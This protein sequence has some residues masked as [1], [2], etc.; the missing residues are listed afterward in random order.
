MH[1]SKAGYVTACQQVLALAVVVAVL[2]P[3]AGV[4]SLDVVTREPT[5]GVVRTPATGSG[6]GSVTGSGAGSV[7]ASTTSAVVPT[8]PVDA[9]VREIALTPAAGSSVTPDGRALLRRTARGRTKLV[10]QPAAVDGFG[11]VGVTWSAADPIAEGAITLSLRTRTGDAWTAWQ[12][13][14]Y[15]PDHGPDPGSA[16][17]RK[18]RPGS[19]PVVLG[20]VDDVQVRTVTS[21]GAPADMKLAVIG[22]GTPAATKVEAPAIDTN[23]LPGPTAAAARSAVPTGAAPTTTT[24]TTTAAPPTAGRGV[25]SL[26]GGSTPEGADLEGAGDIALQDGPYTPKPVI[27][28]RAQ[29][30]ADESMRDASSLHYGEVHAGFIHHT[31]NANDYSAAEVPGIIRSI[32]A[33]HVRSRG[34]SDIGYNYLID[35]FGRIWEGRYGGVTLDPVGAHTLNYND[36]SFGASAIGNYQITQPSEAL[37]QAYARLF[38]WKLAM[39]GVPAASTR[40]YVTSRYFEAIN[41]HRDA[42]ATLCPG[43]YL[44]AQ[45]PRIRALAASYQARW[46]G[47]QR[48]TDLDGGGWPDFVIHLGSTGATDLLQTRGLIRLSAPVT[49]SASGWAGMDT[50]VASPDLTG[51]GRVD[52]VSRDAATGVA[53]VH[54]GDGAGHVG[55]GGHPTGLLAG[56][57]EITAVG[58][59]DHDGH[60]DLFARDPVSGRAYLFSGNGAGSFTRHLLAMSWPYDATVGVGD[61]NGD[62]L[63]DLAARDATGQLWLIPGAGRFDRV[64]TRLLLGSGWNQFD[65]ITG[66]GDWTG[67]GRPDIVARNANGTYVYPNVRN[68][69]LGHWL[70][71]IGTTTGTTALSSGGSSIGGAAPDLVVRRGDALLTYAHAG[72]YHTLPPKALSIDMTGVTQILNVGDWDR[73][74]DD[75]LVLRTRSGVLELLLNN[76]HGVFAA[77]RVLATGF[78]DVQLLT[79]VGDYNGDGYPDLMGQIGGTM[80]VWTGRG[81]AGLNNAYVAHT[82]IS[83]TDQIGVGLWDLDGAPDTMAEVN[84][85]AVLY[86]GNGPGGLTTPRATG[87]S[88]SPYDWV[89]GDG[90]INGDGHP[91]LVVRQR[92]TGYLWVLPG[93]TA[94]GFSPRIFLGEG[95]G[96]FD[97]AG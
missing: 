16:E 71:S 79:A 55:A 29:W 30:G 12:S 56:F 95:Y 43:K 77:P 72:T 89:L 34:W 38:A 53:T 64:G 26:A 14:P 93:T 21:A 73:D 85:Q 78:Q 69:G 9:T 90:D 42:A 44:Y 60:N 10:S 94:G 87:V 76:G 62:G 5:G 46:Y 28:S 52:V 96:N 23:K 37:I 49:A 2:A 70:G 74:G 18:A 35:R 84:G 36:D 54:A 75:D 47:R 57:T 51:D 20:T 3:A 82:A 48:E 17:A 39:A 31:V 45:I 81:P 22:P 91:D 27:F 8:A 15:D 92:G 6:A 11:T 86:P 32:Y 19:E 67:D 1:P 88:L 63:P 25:T 50:I 7:S 24:P 65:S 83:A 66:L 80:R 33:Y 41:G 68:T 40:Q 58:D 97:M 4:I 61:F 59:L 13:L